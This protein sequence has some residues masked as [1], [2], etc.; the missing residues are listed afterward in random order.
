M[1]YRFKLKEDLQHGVRRIAVEQIEKA[2]AAPHGKSDRAVWVHET[3]K[4]LK[5]VRSLLR[6][7][8]VGLGER[9]WREHNSELRRIANKLSGLRDGHV[10]RVTL[11]DLAAA[12]EGDLRE[13]AQ[14]LE[15]AVA[16]GGAGKGGINDRAAGG[17]VTAAIGQ[18]E[19]ARDR[20]GKLD[21]AGELTSV[22]AA[23]IAQSQETAGKAL[24]HLEADPT[25]EHLHELRK[26]VQIYQRQQALVQAAWPEL[27]GIRIETARACAQLLGEAQDLAVL[28]GLAKRQG[29][30]GDDDDRARAEQLLEACQSRQATIRQ[31]ALPVVRR[32]LA[33]KPKAAAREFARNWDAAIELASIGDE[34]EQQTAVPAAAE[35]VEA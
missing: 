15:Q 35:Q 34:A 11:Q 10:A 28:A 4:C 29:A 14:W 26:A 24:A 3:R 20:L 17:I 21:V 1:A 12:G 31:R 2:L 16:K 8:R 22:V 30:D 32:L 27:Q 6:L 9:A 18:L 5:R 33:P 7:V 13:A 19:K 23:G 25:D